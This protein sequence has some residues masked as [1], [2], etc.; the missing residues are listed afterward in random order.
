MV[1]TQLS[2]PRISNNPPRLQHVYRSD[3]LHPESLRSSRY[4]PNPIYF[5]S[6]S[7]IID[8][9]CPPRIPTDCLEL[10]A[11]KTM[12]SY[13]ILIGLYTATTVLF[14]G[15]VAVHSGSI[16]D[17]KLEARD[18]APTPRQCNW[19]GTAPFCSPHCPDGTTE[20][21]RHDCG[22]GKCCWTGHK[23]LCCPSAFCTAPSS[24]LFR[25]L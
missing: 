23:V 5:C 15:I 4:A 13:T 21:T 16:H 25:Q 10:T 14:S 6:L 9:I 17:I 20:A 8:T 22:T 12:K 7:C 24:K 1:R 18:P 19:L 3:S 2:Y 11:R